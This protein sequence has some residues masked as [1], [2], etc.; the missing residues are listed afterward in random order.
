M[1]SSDPSVEERNP[2]PP[3]HV[4][5]SITR[6]WEDFTKA[7]EEARRISEEA[8]DGFSDLI[9]G[10]ATEAPPLIVVGALGSGKTQLLY[11]LFKY[12]WKERRIPALYTTLRTVVGIIKNRLMLNNRSEPYSVS[13]LVQELLELALSRLQLIKSGFH[14]KPASSDL[15][16]PDPG[17]PAGIVPSEFFDKIGVNSQVAREIIDEALRRKRNIVLLIDEVETAYG[18]FKGLLAGGFRDFVE[19]IGRGSAGI[20]IVM[21]VSYLSYYELFLSEFTGD[22]A[23]ARRVRIAQLPP[24]DPDV[25]YEMLRRAG[26]SDKSNT[27]WWFTRGKL[28]WV[29][30]LKDAIMVDDTSLDSLLRWDKA[31]QLRSPL[32]E[33]MS[34]LDVDEL[35]RFEE[36][37]CRGDSLCKAALRYLLLNIRPLK[38]DS[39]PPFVGESIAK[40]GSMLSEV[41]VSCKDL[42]DKDDVLDAFMQDVK[43]LCVRE[44]L[45]TSDKDDKDLELIRRALS[46][47]FSALALH[48]DGK[49][50]LCIG[51]RDLYVLNDVTREYVRALLDTT[52]AYIAE[53][54]SGS[55][56]AS[57][58]VE[59]LYLVQTSAL[60]ET[61][62]F[63]YV[64]FSKVKELFSRNIGDNYIVIGPWA[65][66]Q[67][68]PTVLTNPIVSDEKPLNL[69]QLEQE[70]Q[71]YLLQEDDETLHGA[72]KDISMYI[73]RAVV[74]ANN[75]YTIYVIPLP[76]PQ[77]LNSDLKDKAY[78][79]IK[80]IIESR[81]DGLKHK[82]KQLIL[83]IAGG[84]EEFVRE[85]VGKLG[86]EG[87]QIDLL[88]GK[89]KRVYIAP[90]PGERIP[91]FVKSLFVLLL[92]KRQRSPEAQIEAVIEGLKPVP[93]RRV[94]YF[95]TTLG[96]WLRD[97]VNR[98]RGERTESLRSAE[99]QSQRLQSEVLGALGVLSESVIPRLAK[100]SPPTKVY[101]ALF[102]LMPSTSRKVLKEMEPI[103]LPHS[104][105]RVE[106]LP[107]IYQ[108][109][110][111]R[112]AGTRVI[113]DLHN[114]YIISAI[115]KAA[116]EERE[117]L[118]LEDALGKLLLEGEIPF[119]DDFVDVLAV[120][121]NI[122][123]DGRQEEALRLLY[124]SLL[125]TALLNIR[126]NDVIN[127]Y[128][129]LSRRVRDAATSLKNLLEEVNKVSESLC[130]GTPLCVKVRIQAISPISHGLED[131]INSIIDVLEVTDSW[132][133]N[134]QSGY[135]V[136]PEDF[137][138]LSF[139]TVFGLPERGQLL[140]MIEEKLREWYKEIND[141]VYVRLKG[142]QEKLSLLPIK[143][144]QGKKEIPLTISSLKHI[145]GIGKRFDEVLNDVRDLA[146]RWSHLQEDIEQQLSTIKAKLRD[147]RDRLRELQVALGGARH[148]PG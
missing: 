121:L 101:G 76:R 83:L 77:Y 12:S 46:D 142:L 122:S 14:N 34:I 87:A 116:L 13:E 7:H 102:A 63:K 111:K 40:P 143:G 39:L 130:S 24:I 132:V 21:A 79:L 10:Q 6:E 127:S 64:T 55:E 11:H 85:V 15:W 93:K 27:F 23:F 53:N 32:A 100:F 58:A 36:R 113:A 81:L 30:S 28:G 134:I 125:L 112:T 146:S 65:L 138:A 126:R 68:I 18:E 22:V 105:I 2:S 54:Y 73:S 45:C 42:V 144:V 90:I 106:A 80:G 78:R 91:D 43:E 29:A 69:E 26:I 108:E 107:S 92:G 88:V 109:L 52:M 33:N 86:R 82:S 20:Y 70:L 139:I 50:K 9:R 133:K 59:L 47:L 74:G 94:E 104:L 60:T 31:P 140:W 48:E 62:W 128:T 66:Q 37:S 123:R 72:I 118:P 89:V 25:L 147:L 4:Y 137:M 103:L 19:V 97:I 41:L 135:Q 38:K 17:P 51:A 136:S 16:L 117:T 98:R 148:E 145:D 1:I 120:N 99:L 95:T 110:H 56:V 5:A 75:T 49:K 67:F 115:V 35:L 44:G 61:E 96:T 119:Y 57:K 129:E 71:R 141:K 3:T 8:I 124:K 114:V 84:T 131:E